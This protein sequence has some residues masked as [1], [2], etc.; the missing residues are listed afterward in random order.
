MLY[1]RGPNTW[2]L[3]SL[4]RARVFF[5]PA[6]PFFAGPRPSAATMDALGKNGVEDVNRFKAS[7]WKSRKKTKPKSSSLKLRSS[8]RIKIV[9]TKSAVTH[10]PIVCSSHF[11]YFY[12]AKQKIESS[13]LLL[14]CLFCLAAPFQYVWLKTTAHLQLIEIFR[15][16]KYYKINL[17]EHFYRFKEKSTKWFCWCKMKKDICH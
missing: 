16:T 3:A 9:R 10:L 14:A 12:A 17:C 15:Y 5:H 11:V 2:I 4:C 7:A 6:Q 1:I 8:T 13:D